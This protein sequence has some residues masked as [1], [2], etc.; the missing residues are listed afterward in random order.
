M[1]SSHGVRDEPEHGHR[2]AGE[3][4]RDHGGIGETVHPVG[5]AHLEISSVLGA[6]R[7]VAMESQGGVSMA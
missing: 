1:L 3:Q 2:Q 6:L 5:N 4:D 7:P